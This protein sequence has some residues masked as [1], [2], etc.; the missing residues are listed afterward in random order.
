MKRIRRRIVRYDDRSHLR[1][2]DVA[3]FLVVNHVEGSD[4]LIGSVMDGA[5]R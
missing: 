3:I 4:R 5:H 2:R 1:H